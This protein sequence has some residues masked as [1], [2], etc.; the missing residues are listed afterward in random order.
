MLHS[1][2]DAPKKVHRR[3]YSDRER[4]DALV[5]LQANGGNAELTSREIGIPVPTLRLWAGAGRS[6]L[7]LLP[8]VQRMER[9]APLSV[10]S[11]AKRDLLGALDSARWLFLEHATR[12]EIIAKESAYYAVQSFDKLN[13]A[14]QLLSGGATSRTELSL[15]SFLGTLAAPAVVESLPG[16]SLTNPALGDG[17][18]GETAVT[19][20]QSVV[21][22]SVPI[23]EKR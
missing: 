15:A 7:G 5:A 2:P 13:N 16:G 17:V 4:A 1:P 11:D 23:D 20:D 8:E 19:S 9:L 14:H 21:V 6:R 22:Q 12:P 10:H 3:S 18:E